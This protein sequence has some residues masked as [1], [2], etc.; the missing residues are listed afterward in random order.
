MNTRVSVIICT[1]NPRKQYIEK[2][3]EN[4]KFQSL[5]LSDW[6]LILVDNASD[7]YLS[8]EIDLSWHPKSR[9]FRENKL[10]LTS[11]R[12]AGI[13]ESNSETLVFVDDD[14]IL[15]THYLEEA[16]RISNEFSFV[17]AWGGQ[18]IGEFETTPPEWAKPY[19]PKLGIREFE[20]IRWSNL[21]HQYET[22]PCGAGICVRKNVAEEYARLVTE[23]P[24][25][26]KLGRTGQNL[27][28]GEDSDLAF[29]ACDIGLG[30][31]LFPS[32]KLTHLIPAKRLEKEYLLN[33]IEGMN[34]SHRILDSF[35]GKF[36]IPQNSDWKSRVKEIYYLW[37]T[38]EI[39]K[40]FYLAQK[41]GFE[42]AL[43]TLRETNAHP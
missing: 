1:H 7:Q 12:L 32:L 30:I 18:I 27:T 19:L 25:R 33:L 9:F 21:V 35:R 16:L 11:A 13:K 31:G 24:L 3:I 6:E 4:L 28:A 10:G 8:E 29:T 39:K 26:L 17:G 5:Q 2:V 22:T 43:S 20:E 40:E 23:S 15:E 36:P 34:Y 38:S 37:R 41:R 14:N 42:R